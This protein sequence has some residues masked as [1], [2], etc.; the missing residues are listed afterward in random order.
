M[1]RTPLPLQATALTEATSA[2]L[3]D[4]GHDKQTGDVV[5]N[6]QDFGQ[7]NGG[8]VGGER[9]KCIEPETDR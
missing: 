5:R 4:N 2:A 1:L 9:T 6:F 3:A 8:V 7:G